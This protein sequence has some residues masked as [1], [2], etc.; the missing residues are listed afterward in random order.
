MA[1]ENVNQTNKNPED[2]Y[3]ETLLVRNPKNG[4]VEVVS[5]LET[6]GDRR[7]VS[8][9]QALSKNRPGFYEVRDSNAIANF[10][11]SFKSQQNNAIEFEFF[12]VPIKE[13]VDVVSDLLK[14]TDN[15]NDE[16]GR[17]TYR[18]YVVN[19]AELE[20]VKFDNV[21]IPR[22][23]LLE[24]GIDFDA[25]TPQS[26]KNMLLGLPTTDLVEANVQISENGRMTGLYNL[27]FYRDHNDE[28]KFRLDTPLAR[29]EFE[30]YEGQFSAE[31]KARMA[32]MQ[33]LPRLQNMKNE[34]TGEYELCH[35]GFNPATNRLIKVPHREVQVPTYYGGKRLTS[36]QADELK[37]GSSIKME[38]CTR[39]NDDQN[40]YSGELNYDVFSGT[41]N[42]QE[43][44]Y[45]KPYITKQLLDQLSPE[46]VTRLMNY[47]EIDGA[48]L[49]SKNGKSLERAVIYISRETNFPVYDYEKKRAQKREQESAQDNTPS[50]EAS[51]QRG[52]KR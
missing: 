21:D 41:Y 35:I 51:Q 52:R 19:T 4:M 6:T 33:T 9:S 26:R 15:P 3:L 36:E 12:K 5:K 22:K 30:M 37:R 49:K 38:G 47:E 31:D 7:Q 25:L 8:T 10:I 24:L 13:V 44:R 17:K 14:L 16:Q 20:R 27:S 46:Q 45:D 2:E 1:E 29:P 42:I 18:N 28:L 34:L 50:K 32:K 11:R 23:E 48:G 43:P 40:T 39:Y